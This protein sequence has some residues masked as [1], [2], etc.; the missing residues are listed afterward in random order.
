MI[1]LRRLGWALLLASAPA[2]AV[3]C[4]TLRT[5]IE[6][7]FR[8]GGVREPVLRI[9]DAAA[10][11]PGR[12]VGSCERGARK[13]VHDSGRATPAAARPRDDELLT[14]CKDGRVQRGGHCGR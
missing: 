6:Q 2:A 8:A 1:V 13:I 5:Q 9:V 12:V 14:E 4:D 3:D 7:K 10:S 11:A